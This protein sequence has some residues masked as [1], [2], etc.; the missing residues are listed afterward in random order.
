MGKK[1]NVKVRGKKKHTKSIPSKK[2]NAYKVEDGKIVM[3]KKLCVKCGPGV[4]MA[5]HKNRYSCGSCG[6]TIFKNK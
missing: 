4:F 5:E 2:Y 1:K 6:Y 3:Q